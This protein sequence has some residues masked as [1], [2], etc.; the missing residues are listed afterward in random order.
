MKVVKELN[1]KIK[2]RYRK[3]TR[4]RIMAEKKR[5]KKMVMNWYGTEKLRRGARGVQEFK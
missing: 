2:E 3:S 4:Y 1:N 5:E